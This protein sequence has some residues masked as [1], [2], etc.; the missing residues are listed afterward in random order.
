M[1]EE[2][3][4][5]VDLE[6]DETAEDMQMDE[7]LVTL[8]QEREKH[9]QRAAKFGVE[10]TEPGQR[11]DLRHVVRKEKALERAGARAPAAGFTTGFDLFSEEEIKRRRERAERFQTTDALASYQ[12]AVDMDDIE[13]RKKRAEKFGVDYQPDDAAGLM[14][15]DLLEQKRDAPAEVSRRREA[16]HLY[17]VDLLNTREVLSYFGEYQPVYVEWLDDS[18]CNV[19]FGDAFTA[20]RAIFA[21]GKPLPPEDIPVGQELSLDVTQLEKLWHKGPD[22]VKGGTPIPL[23]FRVATVEDK[24]PPPGTHTTRR[25][26]LTEPRGGRQQQRQQGQPGQRGPQKQQQGGRRRPDGDAAEEG[27]PARRGKR[28]ADD[29]DMADADPNPVHY[30]HDDRTGPEEDLDASRQQPQQ[31][32]QQKQQRQEQRR[33]RPRVAGLF[34]AAAA[35]ILVPLRNKRGAQQQQQQQQHSSA[36]GGDNQKNG[37]SGDGGT[38]GSR[39]NREGLPDA[40]PT[41]E[42]VSYA[43]L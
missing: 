12:P 36:G 13:K 31:Q 27:R 11:K 38:G 19:L 22:F 28:R 33:T 43:D 40:A 17:G 3:E 4:A 21:L 15:I 37:G 34:S 41:R 30:G 1:A 20:K 23:I 10:Y 29:V 35:G 32:Q 6:L 25:L 2:G 14:N 26:W 7:E 16:I 39:G 24:R 8:Q 9:K 5:V 18:S 42:A